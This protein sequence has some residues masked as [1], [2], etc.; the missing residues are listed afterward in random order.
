MTTARDHPGVVGV[1][2]KIYVFGGS[3]ASGALDSMEIYDPATD[4]WTSGPSM[5]GAKSAPSAV[6][7]GGLIYVLAGDELIYCFD[8]SQGTWSTKAPVPVPFSGPAAVA[9]VE[10]KIYLAR[11]EQWMYCY[12][13]GANNWIA[14]TPVSVVRSIASFAVLNGNLYAIGGGE[15]GHEPS[16]IDRIDVYDPASDSWTI[17]GA[18]S[19]GTRRTHLGSPM[20]VVNGKIY[21][22]GGWNG[23]SAQTSVEEYDPT[24]NSW[25]YV[26]SMPMARYA[27]GYGVLG[28]KVYAIGGNYGGSG[29]HWQSRNDEFTVPGDLTELYYDDGEVDY[30]WATGPLG[31]AAVLFTPPQ[32]PWVLARIKVAGWYA[33][34]DAPFYVE[35]WD[36]DRNELLHESYIYTQFFDETLTWAEIDI[37]DVVVDDDFYV[38]VFPNDS[39]DHILWLGFDNDPPISYRSYDVRYDTN[40]IEY[41]PHDDW[42]WT[43]RAIGE[44]AVADLQLSDVFWSPDTPV[45]FEPTS[46]ALTL[47]NVGNAQYDP[48]DGHYE[49]TV[50]FTDTTF[51]GSTIK[52]SFDTEVAQSLSRLNPQRLDSLDPGDSTDV[53]VSGVRFPA[54]AQGTLEVQLTPKSNDANPGNDSYRTAFSVTETSHGWV[55]CIGA[56]AKSAFILLAPEPHLALSTVG[57]LDL[58]RD[59]LLLCDGNMT[60]IVNESSEFF[61][62]KLAT[63]ILVPDQQI[64]LIL[65]IIQMAIGVLSD[66]GRCLS[67]LWQFVSELFASLNVKGIRVNVVMAASPVYVLVTDS[68]GRQVGFL[69]DG[70][71]VQEIEGSEVVNR[72]GK[73]FVLYPGSDTATVRIRGTADATFDLNMT[74]SRG[75]SVAAKVE[76]LNVPVTSA[77]ISTIDAND[78]DYIMNMDEDGDGVVD[79]TRA[80]DSIEV[81]T[82]TIYLPL[83]MKNY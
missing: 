19:L 5:P 28:N 14:K 79:S 56:I 27:I 29:G 12:D 2:G 45:A 63:I 41:G 51:P 18:A 52:F 23:Y 1:N 55:Y 54:A 62:E 78:E 17:A 32:V 69:D 36:S 65:D 72:D 11:D 49:V 39:N 25:R 33:H 46:L 7:V 60:C 80:P 61:G 16:E 77:T 6:A 22:I 8:P 74:L 82:P 83:I 37:P 75:G 38:C 81:V 31:G 35:I 48:A 73:K 50:V 68:Q 71:I 76:Y 58:E 3:N 21:V 44:E 42:N 10:G 4:T 24:T 66:W 40:S 67:W 34:S 43:I 9:V 70:S 53:V 15:P 59:I 30:G 13:P 64:S 47:A 26:T 57:L 20:P